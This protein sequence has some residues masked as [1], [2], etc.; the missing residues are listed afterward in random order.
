MK[1]YA[2]IVISLLLPV[3][4]LSAYADPT[5]L[6]LVRTIPL[7]G[8]KGRIDHMDIDTG[9]ELLYV[10]ALGSNSL[11]VIGLRK[12][13]RVQRIRSLDE[14]QGVLVIPERKLLFITNGGD[15]TL[16]VY[17]SDSLAPVKTIQFSSDADNIR[18]DEASG[19][20]YVGYGGGA[21]GVVD[22]KSL[23]R[24]GDIPLG[25]HPESFQLERNGQRIFVNVP[26][27]GHITVLDKTR[28][29]VVASWPVP[30]AC[31]NFPMA[32]DEDEKR[33]FIGCRHPAKIIVYDTG[34]GKQ[35]SDFPIAGDADDIFFDPLR[36]RI[37]VSSGAGLLQVFEAKERDR[38]SLVE[39]I[40]TRRGARTSLFVSKQGLIYVAVPPSQNR[41][42]EI[43]IFSPAPG[44]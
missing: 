7:P 33:L 22:S 40:V 17:D 12:G 21:I 37:Y 42:A 18:F 31:N 2:G 8:V 5:H 9:R 14:P 4:F 26:S 34:N 28:R 19:Q 1:K 25:G 39:N 13:D 3:V 43:C 29:S 10:A 11:E 41:Q 32:L 23:K 16:R 6:R 35:L 36:R 15:G 20:V 24:T 30:G 27:V 38:L 44:T